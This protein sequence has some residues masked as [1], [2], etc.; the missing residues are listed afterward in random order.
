[1]TDLPFPDTPRGHALME[2]LAQILRHKWETER[3]SRDTG[4]SV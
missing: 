2:L 1:M 4:E 3:E